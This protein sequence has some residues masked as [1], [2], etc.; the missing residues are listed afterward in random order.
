MKFVIE[1]VS[2]G[3]KLKIEDFE[4]LKCQFRGPTFISEA[5]SKTKMTFNNILDHS[6]V[7]PS[8][9]PYV[10]ILFLMKFAPNQEKSIKIDIF[11]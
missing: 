4:K 9:F 3:R 2:Y 8:Q 6:A 7:I 10:R 1:K 5:I 11:M